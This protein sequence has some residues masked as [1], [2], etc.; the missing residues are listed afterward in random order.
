MDSEKQIWIN[1]ADG[2]D[3]SGSVILLTLKDLKK[4]SEY[5]LFLLKR[6]LARGL[7]VINLKASELQ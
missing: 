2:S 1:F 7:G 6:E 3:G 4:F 5:I